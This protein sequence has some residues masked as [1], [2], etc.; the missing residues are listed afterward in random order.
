MSYQVRVSSP[1]RRKIARYGLPD[2]LVAEVYLRLTG[3]LGQDPPRYLRPLPAWYQGMEY[4]FALIDP[5]N[6]LCE[7]VCTFWVV[8]GQDEETLT[9]EN[10][11]YERRMGS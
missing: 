7:H 11:T 4:R 6:R 5:D 3:E 9:V 1:V 2:F 8:Y 10:F